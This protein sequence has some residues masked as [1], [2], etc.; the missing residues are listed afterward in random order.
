MS[1]NVVLV[2]KLAAQA[3]LRCSDMRLVCPCPYPPHATADAVAPYR[4]RR[5]LALPP[6]TMHPSA[7]PL[8]RAVT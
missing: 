1:V 2:A 4:R 3:T 6:V 7:V 5:G 8:S